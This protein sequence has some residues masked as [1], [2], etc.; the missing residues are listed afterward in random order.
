MMET[1]E[2]R[3]IMI[4][5]RQIGAH[6]PPFLIAEVAQAHDGSLGAAH[7]FIDA[8]QRAG[9]DAIKFQTHFADQESTLDEPFR[10]R[11][12]EQD[13]TRYAYWRRM[14]FTEEQWAGLAGH[15]AE[16]GIVFLSS[17]FSLKAIDLLERLDVPAWKIASGEVNSKR[18]LD[19]MVSTG[20]PL[21]VSTG[22]SRWQELSDLVAR[23]EQTQAKLAILQCTSRYPTALSQVGLN[24]IA[25]MRKRYGWPV[26]LSDHSGTP[27]PALAAMAQGANIVELHIVLNRGQFGPDTPASVTADEFAA[28]VQARDA[29]WT[30]QCNAVDKDA[31]ADQLAPTRAI[32]SRS[33]SP[34]R[35]LEG[36]TVMTDAMFVLR[37]P[38]TGIPESQLLNYIGRRL[39]RDVT[40]LHLFQAEDFDA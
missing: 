17:A 23:L 38:G 36:G 12:S 4:G 2:M 7:A 1:T 16:R 18:F 39:A 35:D 22:M 5:E 27:Y 26:G 3:S 6:A 31:I 29:F 40:A 32:F 11:F 25:D 20:K 19:A 30:M 15:A 10:I 34:A 9:A 13:D 8:A 37:K 14:E 21:L 33:L 24:V 28:I